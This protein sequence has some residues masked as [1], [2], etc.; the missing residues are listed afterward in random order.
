MTGSVIYRRTQ[1]AWPTI[2]PLVL[3]PAFI[4]P[5]FVRM[6]VMPAIWITVGVAAVVL[7]LFATLTVTVTSDGVEASFGIGVVSKSV[8]FADVVS[9]T[10][11]RMRWIN[12]WGIHKY[13]GGVLY[14]ANGLSAVEFLLTSGRYVAI[15]TG[16]PD[17]LLNALEQA[18]GKREA[19]H[20]PG[21]VRQWGLQET[22]AVV[23]VS[24]S[25]CL[26]GVSTYYGLQD[27]T[28]I[29][30]EGA[31]YV[32]NG[33]YRNTVPYDSIRSLRLAPV[34][35]P[36]GSKLNGFAIGHT[37]RGRFNVG[38]W[39]ASYLYVDTGTPPFVVIETQDYFLAVNVKD[40]VR[41]KQLYDQ[42]RPHAVR[43][44]R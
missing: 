8:P 2:A 6:Q 42:L 24:A 23:I 29:V 1:M 16:E 12:G 31:L 3:V 21:G 38:G 35:P 14:N 34:L 25:L 36:V 27:P 28:V 10:R 5:M 11:T 40:A 7:L 4:V 39:G 33:W 15:G 9:V 44:S 30:G 13:A 20:E 32:S 22:A 19:G 17:A 18:S 41:T 43:F 26:V 37:M